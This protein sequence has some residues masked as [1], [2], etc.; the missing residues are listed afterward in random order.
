MFENKFKSM[1]LLVF[2]LEHTH[3]VITLTE[4]SCMSISF[5][6]TVCFSFLFCRDFDLE[7]EINTD[8]NDVKE[9]RPKPPLWTPAMTAWFFSTN[10]FCRYTKHL[11]MLV[12]NIGMIKIFYDQFSLL[13]CFTVIQYLTMFYLCLR[14]KV[15]FKITLTSDPK[16]PFKVYVK[17]IFIPAQLSLLLNT[18]KSLQIL[19]NIRVSSLINSLSVPEGTP[20]TAVLKFAAEEVSNNSIFQISRSCW[21]KLFMQFKADLLW[22]TIDLFLLLCPP[23]FIVQSTSCYQCN[24]YKRWVFLGLTL[25]CFAYY[26]LTFFFKADWNDRGLVM[27]PPSKL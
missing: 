20:F 27:L 5:R 24:N 22:Q 16:L 2:F 14:S 26:W 4:Y 9:C 8:G 3:V 17:W 6:K 7:P 1:S 25:F 21:N 13:C 19:P 12:E 18:T 10:D 23:L 11:E 15:T